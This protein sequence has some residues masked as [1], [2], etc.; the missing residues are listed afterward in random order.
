[1]DS[2]FDIFN[3]AERKVKCIAK[4]DTSPY[5]LCDYEVLEIGKEYTV[6]NVDVYSWYTMITLQEFPNKRFNSVLFSEIDV[7]E[8]KN[9]ER[10]E[11]KCEEVPM[12]EGKA[13]DQEPCEDAISRNAVLDAI[14][15]YPWSDIFVSYDAYSALFDFIEGLPSVNQQKVGTLIDEGQYADYHPGNAFRCSKCGGHIIE[16]EC[17]VYDENP[18]CRFCGA[19]MEEEDGN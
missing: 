19:K 6:V 1:M 9:N 7:D 4:Y 2:N 18:Y 13:L 3:R 5:G 12:V 8:Q 14:N 15:E 16:Y 10:M 11:I 17:Q